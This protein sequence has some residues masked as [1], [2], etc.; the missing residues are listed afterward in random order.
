MPKKTGM[1]LVGLLVLAPVVAASTWTDDVLL[2]STDAGAVDITDGTGTTV[3]F[4]FNIRHLDDQPKWCDVGYDF[5]VILKAFTDVGGDGGWDHV[6]DHIVEFEG[7]VDQGDCPKSVDWIHSSSHC[8]STTGH[9]KSR[10][11]YLVFKDGAR[12]FSAS[13]EWESPEHTVT[14]PYSCF[15]T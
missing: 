9:V 2:N 1:V 8:G 11:S 3:Q 13:D 4:D 15:T 12:I 10:V 5:D 6:E 7:S 14:S